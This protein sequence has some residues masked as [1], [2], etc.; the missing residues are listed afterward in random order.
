[1]PN[2][3]IHQTIDWT[4]TAGCQSN[5]HFV[6]PVALYKLYCRL[7]GFNDDVSSKRYQR[8]QDLPFFQELD[9]RG[10]PNGKPLEYNTILY[11]LK[12]T[13]KL[14]FLELDPSDYATHSFR[15]FGATLAKCRGLPDDLTQHMGRWVSDCFQRYFLF[16]DDDKTDMNKSLL[17]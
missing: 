9:K 13:I 1:V 16:S 5:D 17:S 7:V 8:Q 3:H 14:H 2:G 15:R 4:V 12:D 11:E 10:K 6:D